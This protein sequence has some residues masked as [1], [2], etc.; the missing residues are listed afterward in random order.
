M[1]LIADASA[2]IALTAC[3]QLPLLEKLFDKVVVSSVVYD[4]LTADL[5]KPFA[6]ELSAYL[7]DKRIELDSHNIILLDAYSDAGEIS[8]MV[9]FKQLQADRLLI[10]DARGRKVAA[11][12]QIPVI[13][14]MGVLVLAKRK[15]FIQSASQ[16]IEL[17]LD[18]GIY[19]HPDL[20]AHVKQLT[21][22]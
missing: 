4:E 10:D 7:I 8:S 21:N 19:I 9:L 3:K 6:K 22:E 5:S 2:L 11:V 16:S 1:L 12:N 15:G 13:G 20:V 17:M 18:A 14:S